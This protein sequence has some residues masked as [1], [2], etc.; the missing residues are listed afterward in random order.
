M[1]NLI[2][3][4]PQLDPL[5]GRTLLSHVAPHVH[6]HAVPAV[7]VR[8][9]PPRN[10]LLLGTASGVYTVTPSST[11]AGT[12]YTISGRGTV[13]RA[14]PVQVTG[15][16]HTIVVRGG[17]QS[18]GTVAVS[19]AHG[20]FTLKLS[21]LSGPQPLGAT[22]PGPA[23]SI[24]GTTLSMRYT[25][26][27]G[28]GSFKNLHGNGTARLTLVPKLPPV[29]MPGAPPVNTPPVKLPPVTLPPVKLPPV[30]LPPVKLPPVNGHPTSGGRFG[31]GRAISITTGSSN[32]SSPSP[33][34]ATF[35]HG[36]FFLS[37]RSG[38]SIVPVPL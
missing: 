2:H 17:L 11:G 31:S 28:T 36:D 1:R 29:Q 10:P 38:V 32:V 27:D 8:G 21:G 7:I 13:D 6:P 22:S 4:R 25:I 16:V 5:E 34:I 15:V 9:Y 14:G 24:A 37:F 23:V 3:S 35:L 18:W 19:D 30:T 26:L 33:S 20:S 12:D